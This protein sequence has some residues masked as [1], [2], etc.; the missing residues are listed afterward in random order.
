MKRQRSTI[1]AGLA[2]ASLALVAPF[3]ASFAQA[4]PSGAPIT[5]HAVVSATGPGAFYG[6]AARQGTDLAVDEINARGGIKGHPVRVEY[7]DDATNPAEASNIARRFSTDAQLLILDTITTV[8]SVI[9]PIANSMKMPAIGPMVAV[10][11][12]VRE[13]RPYTFSF[14]PD[15]AQGADTMISTW[16]AKEKVKNVAVVEDRG[17]VSSK[18]QSDLAQGL[19]KKHGGT[20]VEVINVP[21]GTV[22]FAPVIS[23]LRSL[24]PDGIFVSML[25]SDSGGLLS[26]IGKAGLKQPRAMSIASYTPAAIKAAGSGAEGVYTY[27]YYLASADMGG[28]AAAFE[29]SFKKR[30]GSAPIMQSALAY[31]MMNVVGR[32]LESVDL[33]MGSLQDRR[34]KI[35]TAIAGIKESHGPLGSVTME[36]DGVVNVAPIVISIHAGK[37]ERVR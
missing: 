17:D 5:F 2:G 25:S 22:S 36:S 9:L 29:T 11:K 30:F 23:R 34:E 18:T 27:L 26:E 19:I 31:Q 10:P 8:S 6:T 12:L 15:M 14:F 24:K 1:C 4:A 28:D 13:N 32:Q 21:T 20:V 16:M 35:R 33:S 7:L 37:E 3:D